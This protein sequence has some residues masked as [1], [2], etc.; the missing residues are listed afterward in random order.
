MDVA[1]VGPARVRFELDEY[2]NAQ[3]LTAW[4]DQLSTDG[5][6]TR[7][8]IEGGESRWSAYLDMLNGSKSGD[9]HSKLTT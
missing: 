5:D 3:L 8:V 1:C 9:Q 2:R 4:H 7:R 6:L